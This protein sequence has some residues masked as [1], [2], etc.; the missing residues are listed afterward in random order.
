M[1][2]SSGFRLALLGAVIFFIGAFSLFFIPSSVSIAPILVGGMLV[3]GGF[4]WMIFSFYTG[5]SGDHPG[6]S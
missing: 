2:Q 6:P 4:I 1:L 3:W 5:Q